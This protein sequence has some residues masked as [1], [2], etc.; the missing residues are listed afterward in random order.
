MSI[1]DHH[2]GEI[3]SN[4]T[5]LAVSREVQRLAFVSS[6]RFQLEQA[7]TIGEV[8]DIR[9]KAEALRMYVKQAGESLEVQNAIA[10]IKL[11]AERRAG[12]MLKEMEKNEGGR[13]TENRSQVATGFVDAP[14]LDDLGLSKSQ[15]SRWQQIATIP[16]PLFERQMEALSEA[17]DEVTQSA[18]LAFAKTVNNTRSVMSSESNEWYTPPIY[19]EAARSLMGGIDLDPASSDFANEAVDAARY[20]IAEDNGLEHEWRGRVWLN[21]PYRAGAA[22]EFCAKLLAEYG[23]GRV[24]EAVVL[25]NAHITETKWFAPLWDHLLCFTNHRINFISP[26]G[27]GNGSTHGSVFVYLGLQEKRFAELFSEFGYIVKRIA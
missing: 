8:K 26:A 14:T 12:A 17:G 5:D 7:R 22:G 19:I 23:A 15:S 3:M 9:D 11:W 18:M 25:L 1:I 16:E 4:S 2:T 6:A 10:E 21:P 27:S 13:P 24:T 20:F